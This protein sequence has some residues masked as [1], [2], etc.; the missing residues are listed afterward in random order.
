MANRIQIIYRD[1]KRFP[2]HHETRS[3]FRKFYKHVLLG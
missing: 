2:V 1:D 3:M